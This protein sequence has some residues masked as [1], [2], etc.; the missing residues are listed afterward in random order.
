MDIK[1]S[2]YTAYTIS[3]LIYKISHIENKTSKL[4]R[5]TRSIQQ[6]RYAI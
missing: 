4:F 3:Q 6:I 5:C 2:Y 1:I